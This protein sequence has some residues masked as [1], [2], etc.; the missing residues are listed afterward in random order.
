MSHNKLRLATHGPGTFVE[1]FLCLF[2]PTNA[3]CDYMPYAIE[4]R[5]R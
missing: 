2:I 1:I 5:D 4:I 3:L